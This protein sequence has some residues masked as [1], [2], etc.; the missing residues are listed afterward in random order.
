[1]TARLRQIVMATKKNITIGK[2][3]YG[4]VPRADFPISKKAY[5]IGSSFQWSVV[6]FNALNLDCRVLIIVNFDK[7]KFDAILG[8]MGKSTLHVLCSYEFHAHEPG[9]HCHAACDEVSRVPAGYMRGPW[10][11]RMPGARATHSR[12]NFSIAT[13][14]DAQRFAFRCYR[15]E[16]KGPLL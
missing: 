9:W 11:R 6:S 8:V 1:M 15:I 13:V 2:W 10:V 16:A 14:Q 12:L 5:N 3:N 4:K 7:Q